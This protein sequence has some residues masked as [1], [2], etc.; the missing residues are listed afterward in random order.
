ML[1]SVTLAF[2][3]LTFLVPS[4]LHSFIHLHHFLSVPAYLGERKEHNLVCISLNRNAKSVTP[5]TATVQ[6]EDQELRRA[7]E[8]RLL[9]MDII[10]FMG[11]EIETGSYK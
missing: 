8:H 6:K 5:L 10:L 3:D 1:A 7:S 11:V 2:E 4:V 9:N